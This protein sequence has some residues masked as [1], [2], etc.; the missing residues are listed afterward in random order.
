M[1]E[2]RNRKK[3]AIIEHL[4]SVH[5]L[6]VF[7]DKGPVILTSGSTAMSVLEA[8]KA[9]DIEATVVQPVYLEPLPLWELDKYKENK[10]IVVEQSCAGQFATLLKEKIGI[11]SKAIIKKY[12]GRPFDPQE[13]ASRIKEV[14]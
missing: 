8:L 6:N 5:T 13:L 3:E 14:A 11:E 12:D 1:Q 4:K 10:V 2:K 9:G 7:G